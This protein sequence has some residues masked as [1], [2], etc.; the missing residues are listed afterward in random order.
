MNFIDAPYAAPTSIMLL[1]FVRGRYGNHLPLDLIWQSVLGVTDQYIRSR[2]T[3]EQYDE[4]Y[5][6][7]N[8]SIDGC[9]YNVNFIVSVT[10]IP[11]IIIE[12]VANCRPLSFGIGQ[13]QILRC[14]QRWQRHHCLWLRIGTHQRG[15]GVSV[16][17]VPSLVLIRCDAVLALHRLENVCLAG[18]GNVEIAGVI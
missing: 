11:L 12:I 18:S 17:H 10:Y 7:L 13:V 16:L 5:G 6:L 3:E 8:V 15:N 1:N 9:I 4:C 14:G 2:I